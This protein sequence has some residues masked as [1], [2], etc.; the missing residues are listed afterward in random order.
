MYGGVVTS[1]MRDS[2]AA[3]TP[4]LR[5]LV[6]GGTGF[7]G[8]HAVTELM[9]RGHLTTVVARHAPSAPLGPVVL[10][11]VRSCGEGDWAA[12]LADHDGVVFAA[13]A[14]DRATPRAPAD[15]Y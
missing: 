2:G 9:R 4:P 10:A 3:S 13:G 1:A 12:M 6:V 5:V 15:D 8:D 14:D 7:L 11:D